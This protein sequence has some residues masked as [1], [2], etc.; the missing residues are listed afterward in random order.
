MMLSIADVPMGRRSFTGCICAITRN[1]K[2]LRI[3]TYRG[4]SVKTCSPLQ[5]ELVQGKYRVVVTLLEDAPLPLR[6]PVQGQMLRTIRESARATVR[7]QLYCSG[8]L[9]L[10]VTDPVAAFEF[11]GEA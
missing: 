8:A 1:G 4:A 11:F 10:D 9:L 6:A 3:A 2:E 7:L 5:G